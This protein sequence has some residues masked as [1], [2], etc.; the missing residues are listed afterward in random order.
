MQINDVEL[1]LGNEDF[2][3]CKRGEQTLHLLIHH[4]N[5]I[6]RA[7]DFCFHALAKLLLQPLHG[8]LQRG[9]HGN[10]YFALSAASISAATFCARNS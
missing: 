4:P 6:E 2:L 5:V 3:A 8:Y 10:T 7:C 9:G 1:A